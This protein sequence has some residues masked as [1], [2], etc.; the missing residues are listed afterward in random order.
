MELQIIVQ[1]GKVKLQTVEAFPHCLLVE[2]IGHLR[3]VVHS[4]ILL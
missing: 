1:L 4:T 2:P 3:A